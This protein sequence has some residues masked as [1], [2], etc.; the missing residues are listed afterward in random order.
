MLLD[1]VSPC[2]EAPWVVDNGFKCC[3]QCGAVASRELDVNATCFQQSV[4]KLQTSQ[5]TRTGRFSQKVVGALLGTTNWTPKPELMVYLNSCRA[6]NLASDPE[7][8][9]NCVALYKTQTRRPYM[10]ATT[11]WRNMVGTPKI[12]KLRQSDAQFICDVFTEIFYVWSRL[13]FDRPRLP[14]GQAI[15]LIVDTFEM[16][17]AAQYLVRFV[18]KL[19]CQ[20]RRKRYATLFLKCC[21]CIRNDRHRRQ[22]FDKYEQWRHWED[23]SYETLLSETCGPCTRDGDGYA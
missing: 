9:L 1:P 10:H 6:R 4:S 2:C 15:I 19:K 23:D 5:Y 11:L 8:L 20:R 18:R 17:E 21:H 3:C 16:G 12:P 14:M 22:R 13:D 7:Q